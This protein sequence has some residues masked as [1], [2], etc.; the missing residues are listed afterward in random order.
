MSNVS[1]LK[2]VP[3]HHLESVVENQQSPFYIINYGFG[4]KKNLHDRGQILKL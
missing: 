3:P 4:K 1:A 2:G